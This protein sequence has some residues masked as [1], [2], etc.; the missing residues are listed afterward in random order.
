MNPTLTLR[1]E[2]RWLAHLAAPVFSPCPH[3]TLRPTPLLLF[4]FLSLSTMAISSLIP[5][6]IA[7]PAS[8]VRARPLPPCQAPQADP[9]STLP[10]SPRQSGGGTSTRMERIVS[11]YDR[12]PKGPK[13]VGRNTALYRF[14][15]SGCV[16]SALW[17]TPGERRGFAG[18]RGAARTA[19]SAMQALVSSSARRPTTDALSL[20]LPA[21]L[22]LARAALDPRSLGPCSPYQQQARRRRH[23]HAPRPRLHQPLPVAPPSVSPLPPLPPCSALRLTLDLLSLVPPIAGHHKHSQH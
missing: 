1:Q 14:K 21:P 19:A 3:R 6:K 16:R 17:R 8:V 5:P 18:G 23:R 13:D 9:P 7:T 15:N 10:S 2:T 22:A 12:L 11:L 4:P 20:L